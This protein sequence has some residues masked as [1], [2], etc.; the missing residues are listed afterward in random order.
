MDLVRGTSQDQC[1]SRPCYR[2]GPVEPGR[3]GPEGVGAPERFQAEQDQSGS[4]QNRTRAVPG[5]TG[6]EGVEGRAEGPPAAAVAAS[7]HQ[8]E[9][10]AKCRVAAEWPSLKQFQASQ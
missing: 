2:G 1:G 9:P 8:R 5:R 3:T 10:E 6:P 7:V 4:R